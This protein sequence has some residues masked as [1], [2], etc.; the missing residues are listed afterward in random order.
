MN[1]LA[2]LFGGKDNVKPSIIQIIVVA[3]ILP[4]VCFVLPSVL[5]VDLSSMISE[6]IGE[7]SITEYWVGLLTLLLE[8]PDAL[9]RTDIYLGSIEQMNSALFEACV[10]GMCVGLCKYLGVLIGLKGIALVQS[11]VGLFFG[12]VMTRYLDR[13]SE[14]H[15][16][17][18]CSLL[19]VLNIIVIWLIPAGAF[20]RK[21]LATLLGLGMQMFAALFSEGYVVFLTLLMNGMISDMRTAIA[22]L[23]TL[24]LP[25]LVVLFIDYF[26]LTP[27]KNSLGLP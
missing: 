10:V 23:W 21:F 5:R 3:V 13:S 8:S 20:Y 12:C 24:F 15:S 6:L 17:L 2:K 14:L 19:I 7:L 22:F 11:I 25:I 26:F 4:I 27:E 18:F 16:L 1:L 9:S